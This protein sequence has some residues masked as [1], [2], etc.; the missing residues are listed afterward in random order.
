MSGG[1][2]RAYIS[3]DLGNEPLGD[4]SDLKS[5]CA[6]KFYKDSRR[7]NSRYRN[8]YYC[9]YLEDDFVQNYRSY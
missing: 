7:R 3:N 1:L 9:N 4:N 5:N 6:D 8:G 2:L